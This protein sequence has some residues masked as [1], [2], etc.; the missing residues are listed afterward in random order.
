[1]FK[2]D[3][4]LT[5]EQYFLTAGYI[6]VPSKP[7]MISL[8]VGS[9]VAVCIFDKKRRSGGI[10]QF[11][12]PY[13]NDPEQATS[14]YGNVATL[15]LVNMMLEGGSQSKNLE[16]QLF[17]GA[18]N[19]KVSSKDIG[20]DNIRIAKRVLTRKRI[21]VVSEDVGGVK[22]R[23]IVFNSHSNEIAVMHVDRLREGDWYPYD[24]DR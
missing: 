5:Q 4:Q 18:Y 22:G 20:R 7:T 1:M 14:R 11:F 23:K 8:V 15:A 19:A 9:C 24:K 13:T 2:K 3:Q 21:K 16:A 12:Y 17:G 10:N 6:Y